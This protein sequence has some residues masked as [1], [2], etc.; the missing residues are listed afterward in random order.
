MAKKKAST[1]AVIRDEFIR[2][3]VTDQFK[4]WLERW[5]IERQRT[6]ADI[7]T[8]AFIAYAKAEKFDPPPR[9]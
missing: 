2:F 3:R 5:A 1:A 6:T 8:Q 7:M 4:A 9:R